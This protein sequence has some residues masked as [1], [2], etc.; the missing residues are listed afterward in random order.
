VWGVAHTCDVAKWD[1]ATACN[2]VEMPWAA[3]AYVDYTSTLDGKLRAWHFLAE[4]SADT[5]K[6]FQIVKD[7]KINWIVQETV[8]TATGTT[9][10]MTK[11]VTSAHVFG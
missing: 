6:N 5:A 1:S 11:V 4:K 3:T 7:D 8:E 10:S 9:P 2:G